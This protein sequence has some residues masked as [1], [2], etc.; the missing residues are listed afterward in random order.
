MAATRPPRCAAA[1][2]D[3]LGAPAERLLEDA[4]KEARHVPLD[5][6]TPFNAW[7]SVMQR[8][9]SDASSY[10]DHLPL[11]SGVRLVRR[12][13]RSCARARIRGAA[14]TA[15]PIASLSAGRSLTVANGSPSEI[16]NGDKPTNGIR[17]D[18]S[19]ESEE[20]L[21]MTA[22]CVPEE[23]TANHRLTEGANSSR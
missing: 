12:P 21:M 23:A 9:H 11:R 5:D 16:A 1:V 20:L 3:D 19:A 17:G 18:R 22:K 8:Y 7:R 10:V 6:W 14:L 15:G 2:S 4:S 13:A